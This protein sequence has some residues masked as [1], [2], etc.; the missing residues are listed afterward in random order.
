MA[1]W[2]LVTEPWTFVVGADGRVARRYEG[3]VAEDEIV[4]AL[5]AMR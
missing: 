4:G 3:L 2:G 1:E 5:E